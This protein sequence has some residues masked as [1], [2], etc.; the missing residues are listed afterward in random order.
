MGVVDQLW[1]HCVLLYFHV[2]RLTN[3]GNLL[4][5]DMFYLLTSIS[6]V[7]ELE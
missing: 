3:E 5:A 6:Y 4:F 1:R 2:F 7:M